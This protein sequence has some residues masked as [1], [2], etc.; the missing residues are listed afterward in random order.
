MYTGSGV[1]FFAFYSYYM[2]CN[3]S[4]G[5]ITERN[6]RHYLKLYPPDDIIYTNKNCSTCK[7][8]KYLIL[9]YLYLPVFKDQHVQNTAVF[10]T[11]VLLN[12]ITTVPGLFTN[13]DFY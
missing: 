10:A 12:L 13:F 5:K 8:P 7:L 6:A 2:A 11:C 1:A 4:P 9:C 3:T